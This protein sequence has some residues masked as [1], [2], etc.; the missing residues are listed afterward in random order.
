MAKLTNTDGSP[1]D[2]VEQLDAAP[3]D[4]QF[5]PAKGDLICVLTDANK[6]VNQGISRKLSL[7]RVDAI[8]P[9]GT[10]NLTVTAWD[11]PH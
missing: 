8:A 10:M 9:D 7:L 5:T 2:C 1:G 4:G 3:I 11:V 6:A